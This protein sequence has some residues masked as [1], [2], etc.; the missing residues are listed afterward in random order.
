MIEQVDQDESGSW[1][2]RL[3][4]ETTIVEMAAL[5]R[6]LGTG[7][8]ARF[9]GTGPVGGRGIEIR[10]IYMGTATPT[11]EQ[12]RDIIQHGVTSLPALQIVSRPMP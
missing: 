1:C 8:T 12:L 6:G 5:V 3:S 10:P 7:V 9:V 2:I 4:A 11:P